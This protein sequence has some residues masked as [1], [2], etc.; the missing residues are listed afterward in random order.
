MRS[1]VFGLTAAVLAGG[2][3]ALDGPCDI[4]AKGGQT[5]VAAHSMTRSLYGAYVGPLYSLVKSGGATKDIHPK[6]AGGVADGAAHDAFCGST[7]ACHVGRIYVSAH[8]RHSLRLTSRDVSVR[9][10]WF[11]GPVADGEPPRY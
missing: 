7:S 9:C 10:V 1:C 6:S 3:E 11:S 2:A 4:Y 8:V 5:C